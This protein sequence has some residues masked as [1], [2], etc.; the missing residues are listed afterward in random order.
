VS[1][2]EGKDKVSSIGYE[3]LPASGLRLVSTY[4]HLDRSGH[5]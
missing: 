4:C 3:K 1:K 2:L 5:T